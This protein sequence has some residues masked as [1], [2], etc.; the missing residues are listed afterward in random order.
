MKK[1]IN[2]IGE[3]LQ[4]IYWNVHSFLIILNI[5]QKWDLLNALQKKYA[6]RGKVMH[7]FLSHSEY[8]GQHKLFNNLSF[9]GLN[10][11]QWQNKKYSK[12]WFEIPLLVQVFRKESK[13]LCRRYEVIFFNPDIVYAPFLYSKRSVDQNLWLFPI[14]FFFLEVPFW[15]FAKFNLV[16]I[17]FSQNKNHL[18]Q[19]FINSYGRSS[20]IDDKGQI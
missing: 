2:E 3:R 12:I 9:L 20:N 1:L 13:I 6:C 10:H 19:S 5:S 17:S 4:T 8:K 11:L 15:N 7:T 18:C 16:W 14:Y